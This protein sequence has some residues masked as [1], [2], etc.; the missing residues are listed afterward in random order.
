MDTYH[1]PDLILG[2]EIKEQKKKRSPCLKLTPKK[3]K[4]LLMLLL[5]VPF[6]RGI[7]GKMPK[8]FTQYCG[9]QEENGH[10]DCKTARAINTI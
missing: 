9:K 8:D 6:S 3:K 4:M 10:Q 2:T 5:S 1:I 7:F